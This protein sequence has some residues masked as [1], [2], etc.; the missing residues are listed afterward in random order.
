VNIIAIAVPILGGKMNFR[1][2][3]G[4]FTRIPAQ[5]ALFRTIQTA[6][7][8]KWEGLSVDENNRVIYATD[9]YQ[10]GRNSL[11]IQLPSLFIFPGGGAKNAFC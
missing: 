4:M 1:V 10:T 6:H 5:S 8:T 2:A 11:I 7:W 9:A 3:V